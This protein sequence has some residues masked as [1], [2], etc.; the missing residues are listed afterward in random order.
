M[1]A[2]K[3]EVFLATSQQRQIPVQNDLA[4]GMDR[5]QSIG[6]DEDLIH[7]R[8]IGF[9]GIDQFMGGRAVKIAIQSQVHAASVFQLENFE[10]Y[11]HRLRSFL[12]PIGG[13]IRLPQ[14]FALVK[15][16]GGRKNVK[17]REAQLRSVGT[18]F[19]N[20]TRIHRHINVGPL[21]HA[22]SHGGL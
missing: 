6:V 18:Q 10:V 17:R 12:P 21:Q 4:E 22:A 14:A 9:Q 7:F 1:I 11:G 13:V 20:P 19:R 3:H 8:T 2:D 15:R 5:C 16:G